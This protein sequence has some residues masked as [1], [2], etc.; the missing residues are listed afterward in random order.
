MESMSLDKIAIVIAAVLS[1]CVSWLWYSRWLFGATYFKEMGDMHL[2]NHP[3]KISML[4]GFLTTLLTAY[5]V[6]FFMAHL[7]ATTVA[8]GLFVGFCVWLG[9]VFTTQIS[10]VIWLK[11]PLKLFFI[12]TGCRLVTLLIMGGVI[13]T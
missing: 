11:R 12:D 2:M 8:D 4:W 7:R 6:A 10:A 13:G 5:F 3:H 9:F 1:F